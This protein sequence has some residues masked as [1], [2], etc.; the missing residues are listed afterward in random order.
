LILFNVRSKKLLSIL[1]GLVCLSNYRA[2]AIE[3]D[4]MP[5]TSA[6]SLIQIKPGRGIVGSGV[7]R[8]LPERIR[9][10]SIKFFK[11]AYLNTDLIERNR[12]QSKS[13]IRS[14]WSG[15]AEMSHSV[16]AHYRRAAASLS[17]AFI[18]SGYDKTRSSRMTALHFNSLPPHQLFGQPNA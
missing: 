11:P 5:A 18:T 8:M 12:Y 14:R 17:V 3:S 9:E 16:V 6:Q 15:Q 2:I 10:P 13:S 1:Q 7:T 4:A